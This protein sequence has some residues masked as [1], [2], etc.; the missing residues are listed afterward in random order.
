MIVIDGRTSNMQ[1]S[2]YNNLEEILVQVAEKEMKNR[3]VTDVFLNDEAFS[4]LY[5]HQAEDIESDEIQKLEVR[6]VSLEQMAADVTEE[7]HK[8]IGL[9]ETG[10]KRSAALLRKAEIGESLEVLADLIDVTRHFLGTIAILRHEF[11]IERDLELAPLAEEISSL[12]S[13]MSEMISAEDWFLLADLA[14]F[15]FIPSCAKWDAVLKNLALDIA[16][17]KAA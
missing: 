9:M 5:P 15:E 13:E 1:V 10:A 2:N 11:S 14:E 8:V 12:V 4:E 7:L 6:S 3:I 16:K 17:H